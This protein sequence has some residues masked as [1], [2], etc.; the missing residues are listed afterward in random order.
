MAKKEYSKK[1]AAELL[2][3]TPAAIQKRIERKK[4]EAFKND[5][6]Q[7]RVLLSD[8]EIKAE[9]APKKSKAASKPAAKGASKSKATAKAKTTKKPKAAPKA[10]PAAKSASKKAPAV[11]AA[12]S[13][14]GFDGES[15]QS[16]KPEYVQQYQTDCMAEFENDMAANSSLPANLISSFMDIAS[17][18]KSKVEDT[19]NIIMEKMEIQR[20]EAMKVAEKIV[21]KGESQKNI[22]MFK[23]LENIE[24]IRNKIV[25]RYD[26]ERLES[27]IEALT[28]KFKG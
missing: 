5:K 11:K 24:T 21:E 6:G 23:L 4:V 17:D 14:S 18:L 19:T 7:W 27:K 12:E 8:A 1:E 28:K 20:D 25:T 3:S 22:Y 13:S 16:V 15:I 10:K 9:K 26:I 2:K